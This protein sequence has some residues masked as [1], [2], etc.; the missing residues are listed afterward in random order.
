MVTEIK[1]KD[2]VRI[3][4]SVGDDTTIAFILQNN[5]ME[6]LFGQT[7]IA[8]RFDIKFD[9]YVLKKPYGNTY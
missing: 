8:S 7:G 3:L 4:N 2:F 6:Y 1:E 5:R 9:K